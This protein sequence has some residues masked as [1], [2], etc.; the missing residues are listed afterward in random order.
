MSQIT[1]TI[2]WHSRNQKNLHVD[3]T[4]RHQG[5]NTHTCIVTHANKGY[6]VYNDMSFSEE[7]GKKGL[8][9]YLGTS[10]RIG[11]LASAAVDTK[12]PRKRMRSNEMS[13]ASTR[14]WIERVRALLFCS[15]SLWQP[16]RWWMPLSWPSC[17]I[18]ASRVGNGLTKQRHVVVA[19][20][21][22]SESL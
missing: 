6:N 10:R 17:L 12:L 7:R 19:P 13:E 20:T 1:T 8:F 15:C 18:H 2:S 16:L 9:A 5:A 3:I 21:L 4:R 22:N 11:G 14:L